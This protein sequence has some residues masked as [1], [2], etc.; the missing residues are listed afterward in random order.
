MK[1]E[2]NLCTT[3]SI[4]VDKS[5]WHIGQV[6]LLPNHLVMHFVVKCVATARHFHSMAGR[7]IR[8]FILQA[9]VVGP[10]PR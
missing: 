10:R 1:C 2:R 6:E 7:R 9:D 5:S 4:Y 3:G 8:C